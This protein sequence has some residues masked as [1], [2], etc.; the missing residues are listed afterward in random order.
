PAAFFQFRTD[1]RRRPVLGCFPMTFVTL[2]RAFPWHQSTRH[3]YVFAASASR[4]DVADEEGHVSC[5]MLLSFTG[6][7]WAGPSH[8]AKIE[9]RFTANQAAGDGTLVERSPGESR[10]PRPRRY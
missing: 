2:P 3:C 8:W 6:S 9:R 1:K 4:G 5:Y 10:C 7:R